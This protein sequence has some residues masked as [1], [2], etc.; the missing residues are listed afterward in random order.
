MQVF[1]R[2][3]KSFTGKAASLASAALAAKRLLL[4]LPIGCRA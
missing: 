3:T 4:K 2:S 1:T